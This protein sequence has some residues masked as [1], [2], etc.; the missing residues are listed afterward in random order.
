MRV[1]ALFIPVCVCC[2]VL[3]LGCSG[4]D[5]SSAP[6][7]SPKVV[8]TIKQ[9]PPEQSAAPAAAPEQQSQQAQAGMPAQ[10]PQKPEGTNQNELIQQPAGGTSANEAPAVETPSEPAKSES[11][12]PG[13]RESEVQETKVQ[14]PKAEEQKGYYSVRKGDSLMKIAGRE[15]TM[16]DPLKW[17]ILLRLNRDKLG[18][19]PVGEGLATW[20]LSP[21]TQL[22]FIT[23]RQAK[24]GL[25]G[26]SVSLWVVNVISTPKDAEIVSP[27]ATLAKQGYPVYITRARV[28]ETDYLR[29][30][31]GFFANKTEASV[32]GEEI[33]NLLKLKDIWITKA[34][35][36]EYKEIAGFLKAS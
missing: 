14:E 2:F 16:Q 12:Q 32:K 5:Q 3:S 33:K 19:L 22:R 8:Q 13:G 23:P 4:E 29:L 36:A 24:E 31:V 7:P 30:R 35:D 15:D 9:L 21:G 17:P 27:A 26:S 18:D 25:K 6:P 28:K 20:E 34:D 1:P 11:K 10:P